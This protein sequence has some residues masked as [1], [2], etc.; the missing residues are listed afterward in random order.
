MKGRTASPETRAKQRA[1]KLG[2]RG[3][4][5][6]NWRGGSGTERHYL[7]NQD[8]YKQWRIAVFKRDNFTCQMCGASKVFL[9]ADHIEPW[10][11]ATNLRY[12]LDNGRTL[13]EPCHWTTPSFPKQLIP[14]S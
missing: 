5:H 10:S 2:I 13:C 3:P 14:V 8:E 4:A 11:V 7:M 9:N 12:S 1:A 6:W